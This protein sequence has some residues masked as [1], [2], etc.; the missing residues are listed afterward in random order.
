[1][2]PL[3]NRGHSWSTPLSK[4]NVYNELVAAHAACHASSDLNKVF[5]QNHF[6][7]PDDM[8]ICIH[9]SCSAACPMWGQEK[10]DHL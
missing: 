3:K 9:F 1:M 6:L 2:H 5:T 7:I 8:A 10:L 4:N